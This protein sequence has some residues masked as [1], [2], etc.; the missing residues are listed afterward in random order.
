MI[1]ITP[2]KHTFEVVLPREIVTTTIDGTFEFGGIRSPESTGHEGVWG[3]NRGLWMLAEDFP[4]VTFIN[5]MAGAGHLN[6]VFAHRVRIPRGIE[7]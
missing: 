7:V 2:D 1:R 3:S 5:G 4:Y 6:P